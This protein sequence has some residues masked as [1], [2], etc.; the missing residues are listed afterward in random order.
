MIAANKASPS[1]ATTVSSGSVNIGDLIW[2][3]ATLS[4]AYS[5]G[6]TITFKLFPPGDAT[7]AGSPVTGGT[8]VVTVSGTTADSRN[9]SPLNTGIAVTQAGTYHWTAHYSGDTNNDA[10]DSTCASEPVAVAKNSPTIGTTPKV[11]L[12]MTDVATLSGFA[13]TP[14]GTFTFKL[15]NNA[16]CTDPA[17][18]TALNVPYNGTI[19]GAT[20]V[21]GTL[22]SATTYYTS[23]QTFRWKVSY[24][25]SSDPNNTSAAS[26]CGENVSISFQ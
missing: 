18:F 7:C 11:Q 5:P 24:D 25:G 19:S 14:T 17:L 2:D 21:S 9:T 8:F 3:T 10:A 6:G 16:T 22:P 15:Y 12:I 4:N 23:G 1:I 13:G 26:S 20:T